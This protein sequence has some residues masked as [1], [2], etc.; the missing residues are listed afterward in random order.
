M[1]TKG[2][3]AL[4]DKVMSFEQFKEW[5]QQQK[6]KRGEHHFVECDEWERTCLYC[7]KFE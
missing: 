3:E 6:C 5:E 7:G 4:K 2:F 1:K